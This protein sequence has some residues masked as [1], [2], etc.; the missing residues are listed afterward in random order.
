MLTPN[1]I[2][3]YNELGYVIP[4][5]FKLEAEILAELQLSLIHI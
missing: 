4:K 1:E 3:Q 2:K 5:K